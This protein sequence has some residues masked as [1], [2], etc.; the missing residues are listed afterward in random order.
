MIEHA[1]GCCLCPP[2]LSSL[3]P[4]PLYFSRFKIDI[5][6]LAHSQAT[7][8]GQEAC[9][10]GGTASI[11]VREALLPAPPH[12]TASR[13]DK[14]SCGNISILLADLPNH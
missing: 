12:S 5:V 13:S 6:Q 2:S 14:T 4:Y 9:M 1:G 11:L 8:T 10:L 3:L 7:P